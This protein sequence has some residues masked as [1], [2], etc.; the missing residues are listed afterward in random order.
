M[1]SF[2]DLLRASTRQAER[3][4]RAYPRQLRLMNVLAERLI[5]GAVR[6]IPSRL[7][8]LV[9]SALGRVVDRGLRFFLGDHRVDRLHD[10]TTRVVQGRNASLTDLAEQ[11][12]DQAIYNLTGEQGAITQVR[13]ESALRTLFTD[14]PS[15]IIGDI[16][17]AISGR[18]EE[19][20]GG[21]QHS[22]RELWQRAIDQHVARSRNNLR[23]IASEMVQGRLSPQQFRERMAAELRT[24]HIGAAILGSGGIL[25]LSELHIEMIESRLRQQMGFLD[26]FVRDT[27][28]R[29]AHGQALNNRDIARA[30]LYAGAGRV[31]F[32][33]SQRQF[34]ANSTDDEAVERRVLG[35][36]EHCV[37]CIEYASYDWQLV[38]TLPPIGDS[39]CGHNC[40][41][42]FEYSVR[43]GQHAQRNI[44][45]HMG[46]F[47]DDR[48]N[49]GDT[50]DYTVEAI[51]SES[52]DPEFT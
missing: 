41:C 37:D 36:A 43:E 49:V 22:N 27:E 33:Q 13:I 25:N 16:E 40:A 6:N 29:I 34:I 31:S 17:T 39:R 5:P 26:Q 47:S 3:L 23:N 8:S 51:D 48:G 18:V 52:L 24:L 45:R 15:R 32:Y 38:G 12:I 7:M 10:F 21:R 35:D 50:V 11:V 42:T 14:Y 2:T 1:P 20:L 4:S 46:A 44:T 9:E 19:A 30:G 28:R